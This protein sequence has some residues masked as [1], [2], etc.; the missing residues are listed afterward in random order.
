M[1]LHIICEWFYRSQSR[2]IADGAQIWASKK[3]EFCHVCS[4]LRSSRP[5]KIRRLFGGK[6]KPNLYLISANASTHHGDSFVNDSTDHNL[7]KTPMGPRFE[8][9]KCRGRL[10]FKI[11]SIQTWVKI[12]RLFGGKFKPNMYLIIANSS[13]HHKDTFEVPFMPKIGEISQ[14]KVSR[15]R[16]SSSRKWNFYK[17]NKIYWLL[18]FVRYGKLPQMMPIETMEENCW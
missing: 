4:T 15:R 17:F 1:L 13:T 3:S 2:K 18:N 9:W 6:F 11:S 14:E 5:V 12:R 7:E 10:L 8:H 16:K